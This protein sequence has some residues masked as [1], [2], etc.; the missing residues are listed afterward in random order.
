M[1][2]AQKKVAIT[3]DDVP[4]YYSKNHRPL[5]LDKLDSLGIPT[6]IFIN[7]RLVYNSDSVVKKF[8]LLNEWIKHENTVLGNHTFSHLRYSKVG[9]KKFTED[10]KKGE[11]ISRELAKKYDKKLEYF[12]FPYNDLGK[13]SLQ[14][15]QMDSTLIELGY[16]STPFTVES[17]DWMFNKVYTI[18]LELKDFDGAREIGELYVSKTLEYFHFFDSLSNLDYGRDINHIYLCHDNRLNADYLASITSELENSG[19]EI[20]HLKEA[21]SDE[22]YKQED[23]YYLK[24]GV[25]W[26]YRYMKSDE[27]RDRIMKSEPDMKE[28]Q[29]MYNNLNTK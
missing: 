25:S 29:Q 11:S 24:W 15:S 26:F 12:R 1:S 27:K 4:D 18:L 8:M 2:Y 21:L 16:I 20:V 13:D 3:I 10:V 19:Y 5:L 6:T 9:I 28:I 14:H 17:S 22:F 23:E 7:E